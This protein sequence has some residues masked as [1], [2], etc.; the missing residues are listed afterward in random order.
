MHA[1]SVIINKVSASEL[2][3]K[4]IKSALLVGKGKKRL[5]FFSLSLFFAQIHGCLNVKTKRKKKKRGRR[6]K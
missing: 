4:F 5:Q 1:Q 2:K 3:R 6:K